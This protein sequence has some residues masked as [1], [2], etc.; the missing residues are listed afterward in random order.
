MNLA[1]LLVRA[2]RSYP[3]R[4]AVLRGAEVLRSYRQLAARSA[5]V[6]CYLIHALGLKPGDRVALKT[7]NHADGL[8]ILYGTC[9]ADVR[10]RHPERTLTMGPRFVRIHGRGESP[11]AIATL[12]RRHLAD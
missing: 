10:R 5:R 1:Q 8:D 11:M 7:T 12:K 9:W 2:A 4:P 6:A 3:E